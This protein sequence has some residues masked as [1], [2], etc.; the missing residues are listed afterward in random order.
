MD[1]V[2]PSGAARGRGQART[3]LVLAGGIGLVV[4]AAL[5][6]PAI[7][8]PSEA[9]LAAAAAPQLTV[10]Q[11]VGQHMIFAYHG[12]K[13]PAALRRRI[14]RGEAAGVI[15]FARNIRS[16]GQVRATM[17]SLQAIGRPAGLRAPLLVMVDQEGG[18]VRRIPGAPARAASSVRSSAHAR[19]DGRAAARTLRR[20]GVN[21]DLAPVADVGRSGSALVG[22]RRIYGRTAGRVAALAGAFAGGLR[23]GG[24][25]ATAK[26]FP[27]LGAASI[28]TD[29][30]AQRIGTSLATLRRVDEAPFAS[31][32][33]DGVDAV[34]L[35]TA[36]YP[37]LDALPAAFSQSWISDEL[38]TRLRFAGVTI[39]DD[40]G[41][42][43][44][45]SFGSLA[46][47]ATLA[48]RAGIDL[49]LFAKSYTA[50]AQAAEGLLR[51]ASDG[52]LDAGSLRAQAQRVL[53]LR[54]RIA[55]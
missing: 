10:R 38:R 13:P 18:P 24:V 40:L 12:L 28:N 32:I 31:L 52:R 51:A 46:Q 1:P 25:L 9:P 11:A 30:A 6:L 22:E 26:H 49:P 7:G 47:Q 17:R 48:V 53:A 33:G 15:L 27:G 41:T 14:A 36:V 39:T 16:V 43:A 44:V 55:G 21:I 42:P 19:A 4:A 37:A 20:A 50:G 35:S 2:R 29:K 54:A 3:A 8:R 45:A 23:M 5:A 34:M